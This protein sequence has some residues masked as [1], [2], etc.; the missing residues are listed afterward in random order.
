MSDKLVSI[1]DMVT[2][3]RNMGEAIQPYTLLGKGGLYDQFMLQKEISYQKKNMNNTIE[4]INTK[5]KEL[6]ERIEALKAAPD[7]ITIDKLE[8][9]AD[10]TQDILVLELDMINVL[11]GDAQLNRLRDIVKDL[12]EGYVTVERTDPKSPF[13]IYTKGEV[14]TDSCGYDSAMVQLNCLKWGY[15]LSTKEGK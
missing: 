15:L 6:T 5:L 4:K 10:I 12:P 2:L 3:V 13:V 9:A 7:G 14:F 11:V 1:D 8:W